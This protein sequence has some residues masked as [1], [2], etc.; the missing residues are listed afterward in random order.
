MNSS[1]GLVPKQFVKLI[2]EYIKIGG[3]MTTRNSKLTKHQKGVIHHLAL[4]VL[5]GLVLAGVSFAGWRIWQSRDEAKAYSWSYITKG[6]G[7]VA[8][9]KACKTDLG[10]KWRIRGMLS[11]VSAPAGTSWAVKT[12]KGTVLSG[13]TNPN[14]SSNVHFVDITKSSISYVEGYMK[15]ARFTDAPIR[16]SISSLRSC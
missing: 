10:T 7:A 11:N 8:V 4:F 3:S 2:L 9:V 5:L 6:N 1:A 15:S 12:N 14:T 16:V 13:T